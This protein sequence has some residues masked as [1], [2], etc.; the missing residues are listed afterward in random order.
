VSWGSRPRPS[1]AVAAARARPGQAPTD[2]RDTPVVRAAGAGASGGPADAGG[3]FGLMGKLG[4]L[5]MLV[6]GGVLVWTLRS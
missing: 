3:R 4:A 2:E 6:A 5:L 1:E